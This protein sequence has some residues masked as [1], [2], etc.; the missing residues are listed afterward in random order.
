M[1][2][3]D[4][5]GG[6]KGVDHGRSILRTFDQRNPKV[7]GGAVGDDHEFHFPNLSGSGWSKQAHSKQRDKE[8]TKQFSSHE[9]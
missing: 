2:Y 6:I 7:N 3:R 9:A 8:Q 5:H 4:L 1:G